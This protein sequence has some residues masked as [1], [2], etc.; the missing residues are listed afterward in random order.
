MIEKVREAVRKECD[1]PQWRYHMLPV[2]KYSRL[3]AE[4]LG[5]DTELAELAATLHDIGRIRHG[6]E[7]H[8]MTGQADAEK[9]LK[10]LGYSKDII[11]EVRHCIES[12]RGSVNDIKPGTK[13]AEIIKNAD[14][15]AHFDT[16]PFLIIVASQKY[17]DNEKA[18]EW[19]YEK[20]I[21]GWNN[22]LTLP[23]AREMV[24]EKYEAARL[25]LETTM[26]YTENI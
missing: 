11:D 21:R 7:N 24:R 2:I 25:I 13:T 20:V 26:K 8:H 6:P 10:S 22:K 15:M 14:A 4:K 16:I 19:V 9:I 17:H 18:V 5:T 12:H 23:D 3:L 1:P